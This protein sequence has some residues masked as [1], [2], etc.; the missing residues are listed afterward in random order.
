MKRIIALLLA[1]V[2]ALTGCG[3][4]NGENNYGVDV[5]S[6]SELTAVTEIPEDEF[7]DNLNSADEV[8]FD[9][10]DDV[11]LLN[12]IE[13]IV[14]TDLVDEFQSEDYII[15]EIN[16]LYISKEYLDE[17]AYNSQSN[18]WFG[19]T[20]EELV[21]QFDETPYV[22]TL[23]EDGTTEVTPFADY[24]D[25]YDKVIRN[26]AIGTG[27][28]LVCVTVSVITGGVGATTV[29][30]I[31]AASAKSGTAMALFSGVISGAMAGAITGIQTKDVDQAIKAA[32]LQGSESF[33]WG[34]ITGA[35]A[36]GAGKA[37]EL[38]DPVDEIVCTD[39]TDIIKKAQ[40]AEK[41]AQE[42]YGGK[43]QTSFLNGEEVPYGTPGA[44]RPDVIRTVGDHIEAMEVKYYNLSNENCVSTL[45]NELK[46]Q[47]TDRIKNLPSGST[48]RI[49]LDVTDR[50]FAQTTI[51]SAVAA[52]R[53]KLIN[54]YPDIPIDIVGF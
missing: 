35:I 28:I 19:Y 9:G 53:E 43:K 48:Q 20:I 13:D 40:D 42:I 39:T 1:C 12:Y 15:D 14:Y 7:E 49:V 32:A 11:K 44:T 36:G 41:R 22:F 21:K 37:R 31:F 23:A 25:T 8:S 33:K 17:V 5:T 47:V 45:C 16:A 54:I 26:I 4:G 51:D 29:S 10:L 18:I 6:A 46:R 52:I 30:M 34:A 2:I 24:D 27:V 3:Q 50:G 38:A